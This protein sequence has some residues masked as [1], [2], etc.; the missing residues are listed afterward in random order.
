[1]VVISLIY[2]TW[3]SKFDNFK[4]YIIWTSDINSTRVNAYNHGLYTRIEETNIDSNI[5]KNTIKN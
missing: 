2:K 3:C 5:K 4:F 1:M